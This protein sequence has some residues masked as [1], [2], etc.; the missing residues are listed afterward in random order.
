MA[1]GGR[2]V[3]HLLILFF[4][5]FIFSTANAN[6]MLFSAGVGQETITAPRKFTVDLYQIGAAYMVAPK[7]FIG[8]S[9]Q[10]GYPES[11]SISNETRYEVF[12]GYIT[13]INRFIPYAQAALG[14]RDYSNASIGDYN[15]YAVTVGSMYNFTD[16]IYGNARY[17]Y[18]NNYDSPST[19]RSNLYGV[20][21]G[22]RITPTVDVETGYAYTNGDY[23]SRQ[24][25]LFLINKF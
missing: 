7:N 24:W 3:K 21:L 4:T 11:A 8:A 14:R 18:R 15:Y 25:G 12:A 20:G 9:V 22:Y 23:E 10:Y 19:W 13:K 5:S 6:G 16:K 17:R 1:K 2:R